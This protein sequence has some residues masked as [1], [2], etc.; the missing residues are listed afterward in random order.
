MISV[1]VRW[2][3]EGWH[4]QKN[5]D[6]GFLAAS[7]TWSNCTSTV[8]TR[9]SY[10]HSSCQQRTQ[11]LCSRSIERSYLNTSSL[12]LQ[13]RK[14]QKSSCVLCSIAPLWKT[15]SLYTSS[16][17]FPSQIECPSHLGSML[18]VWEYIKNSFP[19]N[20]TKSG[21]FTGIVQIKQPNSQNT[22]KL[23]V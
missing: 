8:W 14:H 5:W 15:P 18:H 21:H 7:H 3:P 13:S 2:Y 1:N 19:T 20:R 10:L 16:M 4:F 23:W 17:A 12:L 11:G 9:F 6:L 22:H